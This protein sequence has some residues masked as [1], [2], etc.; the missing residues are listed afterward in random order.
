MVA[1]RHHFLHAWIGLLTN[2]DATGNLDPEEI[3]KN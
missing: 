1:I 2:K 3:L